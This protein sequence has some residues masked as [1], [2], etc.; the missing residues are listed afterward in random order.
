MTTTPDLLSLIS[1][2]VDLP[3]DMRKLPLEERFPLWL[4]RNPHIVE[5]ITR[6]ALSAAHRGAK[7][8]SMKAIFESI[9]ASASVDNGGPV[10]WR[11]DNS[12]T[13]LMARHIVARHPELEGQFEF[14]QRRAA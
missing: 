1:P 2:P 10:P 12:M 14:R 13:A 9:R 3:V 7:R 8:Q 4:E 5:H 6:I 11:L